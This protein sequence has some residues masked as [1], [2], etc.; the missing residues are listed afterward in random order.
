MFTGFRF[1][2]GLAA[3]VVPV[4]GGP[5]IGDLIPRDRRAPV[6]AVYGLGALLGPVFGPVAG[7]AIA[8]HLSWRWVFHIVAM[9][10]GAL[11]LSAFFLVRETYAPILRYRK[12]KRLGSVDPNSPYAIHRHT[13]LKHLGLSV[14][15]PLKLLLL[16]PIV[17]LLSI[18]VAFAYGYLYLLFTTLPLVFATQYHFDETQSGLIFIGLGIG[19]I[20]AMLSVGAGTRLIV[21][22]PSLSGKNVPPEAR[23][24]LLLP[25]SIC[26][27]IGFFVYGW[28]VHANTHWIWPIIGTV[29]V[30]LGLVSAFLP[31]IQYLVDAF[32]IHAASAVAANTVLRS[33]V[34]A[35]FPL[36]GPRMFDTLGQGWGASLLAFVSLALLPVPLVFIRWGEWMR[37]R[38]AV[39]L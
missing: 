21:D 18:Y 14:L 11:T 17:L 31:V 15:R 24:K 33:L 22:K 27:P 10:A 16:S 12:Q 32:T 19:M 25:G 8:Q 29:F 23:L 34:G 26:T 9:I 37:L 28:T 1:L 5:T 39:K 38:Y 6:L 30:G 7:G 3:S 2:Q 35:F 13:A 36:I 4:L 20:I